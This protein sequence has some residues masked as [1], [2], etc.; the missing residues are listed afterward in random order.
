MLLELA[1]C[2]ANHNLFP[3]FATKLAL[4]LCFLILT[5]FP[6]P[7]PNMLTQLLLASL[8]QL[9][10]HNPAQ[11][12]SQ[13]FVSQPPGFVSQPPGFPNQPPGFVSQ[14]PGF[15]SQLTDYCQY[16]QYNP[17]LQHQAEINASFIPGAISNRTLEQLTESSMRPY[18]AIKAA[19]DKH[20]YTQRQ[21]PCLTF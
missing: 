21:A 1:A 12:H 7:Y 16:N 19:T 6:Q 5:G 4:T 9:P 2:I 13:G 18:R 11:S 17:Y 3:Y 10:M 20:T 15:V 14:P 8:A